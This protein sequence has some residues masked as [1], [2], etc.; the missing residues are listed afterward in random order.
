MSFS[1]ALRCYIAI[2]TKLNLFLTSI[3]NPKEIVGSPR[4]GPNSVQTHYLTVDSVIAEGDADHLR[5]L[6]LTKQSE[7]FKWNQ[8]LKAYK[9]SPLLISDFDHLMPQGNPIVS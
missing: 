6:S 1:I 8:S 9:S 4:R 7:E 5:T 3:Q 2:D